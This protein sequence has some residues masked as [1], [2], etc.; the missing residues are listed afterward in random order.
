MS[1]HDHSA[2]RRAIR[3]CTAA[4][5]A[6]TLACGC[7]QASV[8]EG[9][10]QLSSFQDDALQ[11]LVS[12]DGIGKLYEVSQPDGFLLEGD[13][14]GLVTEG[15][16]A[17]DLGPIE[18]TLSVSR[19]MTEAAEGAVDVSIELRTQPIYVPVRIRDDF[20]V[21]ICRYRLDV[22][23]I[24]TS[25]SV[26]FVEVDGV[27]QFDVTDAAEVELASA[28]VTPVGSCPI[29]E[30]LIESEA[31]AAA[32]VEYVRGALAESTAVALRT[33]PLDILGLPEQSLEIG[34]ISPFENRRG[35]LVFETE[36]PDRTDAVA[37]TSDGLEATLAAAVDARRADCAP[38]LTLDPAEA[39]AG[40]SLD[41]GLIRRFGADFA[42]AMSTSWL[43][44]TTQAATLAG[45]GCIGLEDLRPLEQS[46]TL[47]PVDEVL[48][49]ELGLDDVPV[50][51][52]VSLVLEP[53][54]LPRVRTDVGAST[55][56]VELADLQVDAY[57]AVFGAWTRVA[58]VVTDARLAL[59][60][61]TPSVGRATLT[62]EAL[63]VQNS[64]LS[65]E[66]VDGDVDPEILARWTRRALLLA[67]DDRL[68]LPLP[69][70]D[71]SAVRVVNAQVR[72]DDVV[73]FLRFQ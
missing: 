70:R 4:V 25:A 54:T 14:F 13:R 19:R 64:T 52:A 55:I 33:S 9:N 61:E 50:D 49:G 3:A 26:G 38:P 16:V 29:D 6:L 69:L 48:L 40:A 57:G 72:A 41:P 45:F 2:A 8:R 60:L 20:E 15:P 68:D 47:F 37:L 22:A 35:T 7:D 71:G 46:E 73:L 51:D 5:F 28:T 34:R 66:L 65:G 36:T 18:Q 56:V 27:R 43:Q 42:L 11:V 12:P 21:R 10:S 44:R 30:K 39:S 63:D 67:L 23:G 24:S 53:G 58:S 17:V 1:R 62:L 31:L 32:L 59:R